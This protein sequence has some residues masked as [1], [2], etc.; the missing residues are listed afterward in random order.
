M[1]FSSVNS[2]WR[3][4]VMSLVTLWPVVLFA[5]DHDGGVYR[6]V[7]WP[8]LLPE[9][10]LAAL[11]NPP[12]YLEEIADGSGADV[13]ENPIRAN[14]EPGEDRYQ[15]ALSSTRVRAEFDGS[16]IRIPGFVV[17]LEFDEQQRVTHFFLVPFFG[18]CIHVPPPPPNQIIYAVSDEGIEQSS[19]YDAYWVSGQ[20]ATSLTENDM[21]TSAY[22]MEVTTVELYQE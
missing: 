8:D 18:A 11:M 17:P 21:A 10:D 22:A 9:A 7:E 12:E 16:S 4:A 1:I 3:V 2:L 14:Q 15:Q 5:T 6:T 20:L 13:L 19:L